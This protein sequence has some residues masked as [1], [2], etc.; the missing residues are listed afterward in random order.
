M[1]TLAIAQEDKL[2]LRTSGGDEFGRVGAA[3]GRAR[4]LDLIAECDPLLTLAPGGAVAQTSTPPFPLASAAGGRVCSNSL[5][6]CS[7]RL[8]RAALHRTWPSGKYA[9]QVRVVFCHPVVKA[10]MACGEPGLARAAATA[11]APHGL[12]MTG[13]L[14]KALAKAERAEAERTGVWEHGR[15]WRDGRWQHEWS[16]A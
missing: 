10:Y 14:A 11:F 8:Q 4:R 5:N 12:P 2:R 7:G 1:A 16:S 6:V 15:S 3:L 9:G 13:S